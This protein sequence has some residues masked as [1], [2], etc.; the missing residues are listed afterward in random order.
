MSEIKGIARA[1]LGEGYQEI[2]GQQDA[3]DQKANQMRPDIH[4]FIVQPE[5]WDQTLNAKWQCELD[6]L[7]EH[8][9]LRRAQRRAVQVGDVGVIDGVGR[10]L[11]VCQ[12][13]PRRVVH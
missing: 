5:D 13:R 9:Y 1:N 7:N 3:E 6:K 2:V 4:R 10:H 8:K 11:L 12:R